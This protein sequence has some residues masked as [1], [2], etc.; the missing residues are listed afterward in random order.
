MQGKFASVLTDC[1]F[2][3][4]QGGLTVRVRSSTWGSTFIKAC[5]KGFVVKP[6][7]AN[8]DNEA[9]SHSATCSTNLG[10]NARYACK[11]NLPMF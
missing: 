8:P 9:V 3:A 11:E 10:C 5:S 2:I 4:V 1:W 7:L 6:Y